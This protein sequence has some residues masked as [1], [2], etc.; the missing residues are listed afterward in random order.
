MKKSVIIVLS[1]YL[2]TVASVAFS[3]DQVDALRF[4]Q[5]FFQADARSAGVGNAFG[6]IGANFINTSINP[7]GLAFYRSSEFSFSMGFST[8]TSK[9]KYLGT[10]RSD[11][12]YNVN[13]PEMGLVFTNVRKF[14]GQPV[15]SGWVS[16][17]FALGINRT[18]NF[19]AIRAFEGDN[20]STS[21]LSSYVE[22]ANGISWDK[23]NDNNIGGLA[24]ATFCID[25]IPGYSDRYRPIFSD[26]N[27]NV[28]QQQSVKSRGSG[29]DINLSFAG[30]YSDKIYIGGTL[31]MPTLGY[32][33]TRVFQETNMKSTSVDYLSHR[34]ERGL[35]ISGVGIQAMFGV[36]YKPIKYLRIGGSIQSPAYYDLSASYNQK[37][38]SEMYWASSAYQIESE[39]NIDFKLHSPFRAT[40]SLGVILDKW[41]FIGIDYEFVDYS[42]AFFNSDVYSYMKENNRIEY[43]YGA[44]NNLRIGGEFKY[45][46]FAIRAGYN[47]YGSPYNDESKPSG[48]DGSTRILSF[49]LGVRDADF[50]FDAAYQVLQSKEFILPYSIKNKEVSGAIDQIKRGNL[51]F[52]FGLK[53]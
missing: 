10:E 9:G 38:T 33:E 19:S 14:K 40:A 43:T 47:I 34:Y 31:S 21:I 11:R 45:D 48:A 8:F 32:H 5:R 12:K 25:T 1:V 3:Q 37:M 50:F 24:W 6:A 51:L 44:A 36:I 27:I 28:H 18:N 46:I 15:K 2:T 13:V 16:S 41:G 30:N 35:D 20:S 17:T 26:T 49:G 29:Y 42:L 4:S 7:A 23:L 52:T 22:Y 53:F 39:G